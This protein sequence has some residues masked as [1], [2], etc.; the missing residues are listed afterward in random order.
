MAKVTLI[1]EDVIQ[2][3]KEGLKFSIDSDPQFPKDET[4]LTV[5]Q[6]WGFKLGEIFMEEMKGDGK[7][8]ETK[9]DILNAHMDAMTHQ[10][11]HDD[12]CGCHEKEQ[13]V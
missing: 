9:L 5:A 3:G 4:D 13:G 8:D 11:C 12:N 2:D 6:S 1:I 10:H 7:E